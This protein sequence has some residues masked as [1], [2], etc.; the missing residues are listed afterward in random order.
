MI[1]KQ[2]THKKNFLRL[3]SVFCLFGI[4]YSITSYFPICIDLTAD[5]RYTLHPSTKALLRELQA[6]IHID[7]YLTGDLPIEFKQLQYSLRTLLDQ[8]QGYVR[9]P[10]IR[11]LVDINS[12]P[13]EE[14]KA[15]F[16]ILTEHNI[17]P[18]NVYKEQNGERREKLIYPGIIITSNDQKVGGSILKANRMLSLE[19]MIHQSIENLEYEVASLLARLVQQKPL[20]IGLIEGHGSPQLS[21]LHG[22][23]QTLNKQYKLE[24][25]TLS[26]ELTDEYAALFMIKPQYS[27]SESEKY[28]LDQYIMKGGKVLFFI[29][30]L[31]ISMENLS[32]GKS[33]ALPLDL[34][35]DD[36][37][38]RYGVRINQDLI[39]DL[40]S[41]IYPIIVGKMGNQPQLKFLPWPFFPIL[42]HFPEHVIT[43]N[44]NAVYSQFINSIDPIQVQDIIQTPLLCSSPYS[45]KTCLPVYINLESLRKPPNTRLYEQGPIPVAYLLE[46]E[47]TSLYK[48]RIPPDR[49]DSSAFREKSTATKLLVVSSS[50]L[51]LNAVSPKDGKPLSWGYDPFLQQ[52]F[53]NPDFVLNVLSYMLADQGMINARYKTMKLRLVNNLKVKNDKLYWQCINIA[54]PIMLLITIGTIAYVLRKRMIY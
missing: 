5:K 1:F 34:N 38:F 11:S 10:I 8:F 13:L 6:P 35:L 20:R 37:L 15:H 2:S 46:G 4:G 17:Q 26:N 7:I 53:A 16:K 24:S 39:Q 51:L 14:R 22:F 25:V 12:L 30:R 36:L 27:F 9:H 44:M 18:T 41:G 48:H 49:V 3:L 28:H 21:Y 42:N 50:S 45:M 29:E 54:G 19:I 52:H 47:F 32:N 40:Q 33:L 43:K 31:Q 23:L